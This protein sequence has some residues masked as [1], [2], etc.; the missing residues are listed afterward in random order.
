MP[1]ERVSK[2]LCQK[3]KPI[4]TN[5]IH[6]HTILSSSELGVYF[7]MLT[8]IT[9]SAITKWKT[10]GGVAFLLGAMPTSISNVSLFYTQAYL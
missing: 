3:V 5:I 8:I 2:T 7:T 10:L 9:M 6:N 4:Q 1:I